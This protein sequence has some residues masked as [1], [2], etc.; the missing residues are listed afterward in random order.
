[1]RVVFMGTPG[2]AVPTLQALFASPHEVVGVYCQP[3]RPAGRGMKMQA[4]PIQQLA[5][6]HKTPVFTPTSLKSPEAQAEFAALKPEVAVVAAYGLLL[7]QAILDTPKHGCINIHPS[8]LPRWRGAAPIQRTLMAGDYHTACC[9]MQMEA[10]LDTGPVLLR[11]KISINPQPDFGRL[12]DMLAK[13]GAKQVLI[14]LDQ[15]SRGSARPVPQS[16]EG[17][18][19]AE[20]ITKADRALHWNRTASQLLNQIRALSPSPAAMTVIHGEPVKI[21]AAKVEAGDIN[22]PA[23]VALDDWLLINAGGGTALRIEELQRSGKSRQTANQCLQGFAV[24]V[25]TQLE[26][27]I[28]V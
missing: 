9:I 22:K 18:T 10:G 4:S 1:M 19:Y 6:Q 23:G 13:L 28:P 15:L 7:P 25:G 2:F 24:P 21:F 3:P 12:H 5:E 16:A 27:S 11:E 14:A 8:D 17:V 26:L 20:K